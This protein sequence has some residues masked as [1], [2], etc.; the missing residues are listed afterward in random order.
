MRLIRLKIKNIASLKGEHEIDFEQIQ[1]ASPLF[2]I[3]GETGSGKSSI[4]NCIGLSIY[5]EIIK[6][7]VNQLDVVSLG[8][9]EGSIELIFQVKEKFYFAEWR[10]R[11][12]K[13]NGE[14]YSTPRPPVRNLYLLERPEFSSPK[15]I[16]PLSAQEILNLNFDQFCKCII[17][18][19]GEF[20]K[21]LT[22]SFNDRKEILEKLYPGEILESMGREL[23]RELDFLDKEKNEIGIKLGELKND[24]FSGEALKEE[25][26]KYEKKMKDGETIT[27]CLENLE[28]NFLE[29]LRHFDQ[30]NQ[31]HQKKEILS[32]EIN[33][34]ITKKEILIKSGELI[35]NQYQLAKEEQ[36]KRIPV[37][38]I[39][40]KKE[41]SLKNLMDFNSQQ[42]KKIA[43]ISYGVSTLDEKIA[44]KKE[45]KE[46]YQKKFKESV[47]ILKNPLEML[48]RNQHLFD[49]L[50]ELFSELE[51]LHE[52]VKGK[53]EHLTHLENAGKMITSRLN[54]MEEELKTIPDNIHEIERTTEKER[55]ELIN[56][57]DHRQRSEINF[58]EL[59][60]NIEMLKSEREQ[61]QQRLSDLSL[62]ISKIK[63]E[64]LPI[65]TT[66]KLEEILN[67]REICVDH[68]L[69][70]KA[71]SCPVCE[72]SVTESLWNNLKLKLIETNLQ[73]VRHK[74]NQLTKTIS[75]LAHEDDH[76][77]AKILH[78]LVDL[79]EKE[80]KL[81]NEDELR[82]LP[83]PCINEIDKKLMSL[84]ESSWKKDSLQKE[85]Y[86][87][88]AE[89]TNT[90]EQYLKVK[91]NILHLEKLIFEKKEQLLIIQNELHPLI[92]KVDRDTIRELKLEIKNLRSCVEIELVADKTT[93][94]VDA[95]LEKITH[96][97][98]ELIILKQTYE[99]QQDN[100]LQLEEELFQT[101]QGN[102]AS[103]IIDK[104][105]QNFMLISHQWNQHLEDQ[106]N[107][108]YTLKDS[109]GR[110][111]Q[112]EE[113]IKEDEYLFTKK[114]HEL[115]EMT[116]PNLNEEI[117]RLKELNL[118]LHS[119]RDIFI[120][121]VD[122]VKAQR[123][124]I[125]E[126]TNE[127]VMKFSEISTRLINWEQLQ[128]KIQ[129]LKLNENEVDRNYSRK[130]RLY[131][132]LG[133]DELRTFVL[134]LVEENLIHQTNE[135][136]QKLCQGRYEI[137]HHS[138]SMKMTP[139]FYILDKFCEDGK[140]KV[141]TLS[142]GETF[143]VSLAMALGLA[144]M[145]RGRA[146]I[147][148]L[149]IDEGFGTLDNE[150]LEDVLDMLKQIQTRG[151]MVGII[152]H[153]KALTNAL[154]VNLVLN[155]SS[156][157]TSVMG[158]KYN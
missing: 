131:E 10:A 87:K 143:M 18:N 68:A 57:I 135:E 6:K 132:V 140:R 2:A 122:M 17:L 80:N 46:N 62:I 110:F 141:S 100:I 94:E 20:A 98:D 34:L 137:V 30:Y 103:E 134:S 49:P 37:L 77:K 108:E 139:E 151:L 45:A 88:N 89:R 44:L 74:F 41:E 154:P 75:S 23:K 111:F 124:S 115:K 16:S 149:F 67:A 153:I 101:L 128:E 38:Q 61:N 86:L 96:H 14:A 71:A 7:N 53:S 79:Q 11:V 144:E 26:S 84:K 105:N 127:F 146:E 91:H 156:D 32:K 43:E 138:K 66:L 81:K 64:I 99:L 39:F 56:K 40:L 85:M 118:E 102:K 155:K 29:L 9:K 129:E 78:Q 82:S 28:R 65:E 158:L 133:K 8:E 90:R 107:E 148:S 42:E 31:N 35:L 60:K 72:Q 69:L 21:F 95:L 1:N 109:Q 92:I 113:L 25:K 119:L 152:S 126:Q 136:L 4:L 145:T 83:L 54:L 48:K 27:L 22:S 24:D 130:M 13:Q 59:Y 51:L 33:Q 3:T 76:L 121:C 52:E 157:G 120:T 97:Q 73:D 70:T 106:R 123:N 36:E 147:D 15:K 142:G 19:Q 55:L 116:W 93:L 5:G 114:C 104:I 112:L 58:H 12:K 125:R 150:S 47:A 50:F 117:M 63:I